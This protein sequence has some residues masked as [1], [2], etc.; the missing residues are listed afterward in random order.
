MLL[1][2]KASTTVLPLVASPASISTVFPAGDEIRIASPF[3]GPTSS[4]RIVSSPP[5][6]GGGCNRHHGRTNFQVANPAATTTTNSTATAQPQPRVA[7]PN[8]NL[9]S[10]S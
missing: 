3:T 6:A 4:T 1:R 9:V 10:E 8:Q 7:R 2:F 5:D